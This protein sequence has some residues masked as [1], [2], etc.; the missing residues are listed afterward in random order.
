VDRR[1]IIAGLMVVTAGG[2]QS[3]PQS[4]VA[5]GRRN[6]LATFRREFFARDSSYSPSQRTEAGARLAKLE[7]G[8]ATASAVHFELELA[9]IVA[10][11]DNGHT[12]SPAQLRSRRYARVPLRFVP[13]G[14]EFFVLR[15]DTAHADLLGA[16][17]VAI[18]G[19]P[20]RD[21]RTVAHTLWGGTAAWRDRF[22]PFFIESPDQMQALGVTGNATAATYTLALRNG[23]TVERRIVAAPPNA[24]RE[25]YGTARWLSPEPLDTDRGDWRHAAP[26]D[27]IPWA[28]QEQGRLFR[29]REAPELGALIIQMRA[30]HD[31]PG[32][33]I[34]EFLVRAT[35]EIRRVRPRHVILD[36]RTNGG[37][38]LNNTRDFVQSLPALVPGRV[39]VLTSP[40]T[41][42][43]AISTTG[44][45]KQAG[46]DRVTIVGEMVGDRLEFWAEGRLV[47]LPYSG[48]AMSYSSQRHDYHTGCRPYTDCHGPVVRNPISVPTLQPDIAAPI[49][50]ESIIAGRDPGMEAIEKALKRS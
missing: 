28:F 10:L 37:G 34:S 48:A 22:V 39:F 3:R 31:V 9:R 6:D 29:T 15:A 12:A 19:K 40:W 17:L 32:Q 30:N 18:D 25:F 14:N 44:Y 13:L 20:V 38:D 21:V 1:V 27:R 24:E 50:P 8:M 4:D 46:R 49:T 16:R 23:R 7:A 41:F 26:A 35:D 33:S 36:L 43:A 2:L 11:S 5:E 42:S 45:L 47:R